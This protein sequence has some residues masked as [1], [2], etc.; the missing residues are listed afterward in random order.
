MHIK[1]GNILLHQEER[2][3]QVDKQDT[4][5]RYVF[6]STSIPCYLYK[7]LL[8]SKRTPKTS[9]KS[10]TERKFIFQSLTLDS[11]HDS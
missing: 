1:Q 10:K 6:N 4:N 8:S 2:D 5:L 9:L 3:L 7:G 11:K